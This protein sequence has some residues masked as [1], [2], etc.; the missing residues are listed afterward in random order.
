MTL[1][2]FEPPAVMGKLSDPVTGEVFPPR[3]STTA[4]Q[5]RAALDHSLLAMAAAGIT[6]ADV[7]VRWTRRPA[8]VLH[9]V[10]HVE[11]LLGKRIVVADTW[12]ERT[13]EGV[14]VG[15]TPGERYQRLVDE[16]EAAEAEG[17]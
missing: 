9:I 13:L 5:E 15:L 11:H 17:L 6:E 8:T 7:E 10:G 3:P 16:L 4:E 14:P 2:P 1:D 12:D